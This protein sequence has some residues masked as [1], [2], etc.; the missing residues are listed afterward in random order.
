MRVLGQ[1]SPHTVKSGHHFQLQVLCKG[2]RGGLNEVERDETE[3]PHP[4]ETQV[5]GHIHGVF[6]SAGLENDS[7]V[8]SA[9]SDHSFTVYVPGLCFSRDMQVLIFILHGVSTLHVPVPSF[10]GAHDP[11]LLLRCMV[12]SWGCHPG[13]SRPTRD[14]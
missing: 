1:C 8:L 4:G 7:Q 6:Y 11:L 2:R 5:T 12:S 10:R 3:C 13:T 14:S 9:G